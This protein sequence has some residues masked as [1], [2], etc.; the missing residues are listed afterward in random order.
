ML[1]IGAVS[2]RTGI[3]I[4]TIRFYEAEGLIDPP[5][6][7]DSGR[8]LYTEADA[9]R[10]SF[11]R[12]ARALGFELSDIRS[13]LD[14]SDHPD[15]PCGEADA[16]AQRH[17]EDVEAR[18]AQ[19]LALRHELARI[20]TPCDAGSASRCRVIETLADHGACAG[21]HAPARGGSI[22]RNARRP[23]AASKG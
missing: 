13:L 17:L 12:H 18:I 21:D 2:K 8:R 16:I 3:K 15:R 20:A 9:Q 22:K 10:L 1:T 4:P 5:H 23:R 11:I 14:L 6:R 7:S 19:L